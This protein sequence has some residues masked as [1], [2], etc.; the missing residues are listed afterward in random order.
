MEIKRWNDKPYNNLD[1]HL[2]SIYGKKIYKI[3]IDGGMTCPNRDGSI[4]TRGCIFC[5]KGG[6]GEF[7]ASFDVN[8]PSVLAQ[9]EKGKELIAK[10]TLDGTQ[11]I[12]YFQPY[13]NTYASIEYLNKLYEEALSDSECV[14][15]SIGTRPD[16]LSSDVLDLLNSLKEKYEEK[17]IWIELGLQTIHRDT[18]IYIRRGYELSRF[19]E[20]VS[21]LNNIGIPIIV[22]LI[23]GLPGE[24]PEM[25]YASIE[26]LNTFNIFGVKLQLLHVLNDTDLVYDYNERKFD[27]LSQEEYTN[28]LIGCIERL[29]PEIVI[30][31]VTGDGPKDKLIAPD[32]SKNKRNVLNTLLSEMKKR[33]T[34][35]GRLYE[36]PE[37][38]DI[39]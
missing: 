17:L 37:H 30:H 33:N 24:T 3:A 35:Q 10:K 31:R 6:S 1:Y 14:G 4:D 12:A 2:K 39:I 21:N 26:Y 15:L 25:M 34:W 18:A 13:S 36:Q 38:I 5:S 8:N 9:L 16:C 27:V 23:L 28:I 20:A 7:A 32:W 29:N 22:H 11:Y 19:E